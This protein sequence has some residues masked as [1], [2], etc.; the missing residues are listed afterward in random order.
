MTILR[1]SRGNNEK[2]HVTAQY[3]EDRHGQV[4]DKSEDTVPELSVRGIPCKKLE[5]RRTVIDKVKA[6]QHDADDEEDRIRE[7]PNETPD[8]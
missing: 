4:V 1:K 7:I 3:A 8:L 5:N 2:C 6:A